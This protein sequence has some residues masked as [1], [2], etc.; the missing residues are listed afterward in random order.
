M[1]LP[2]DSPEQLRALGIRYMVV[3]GEALHLT[4]QTIQQ[5][6]DKYNA[7]LVSEHT[8]I[9]Q[10]DQISMDEDNARFD[11]PPRIDKKIA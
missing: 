3:D 2:D 1:L 8:F 5:W 11:P 4:G 9:K 7:S 10:S 6:M